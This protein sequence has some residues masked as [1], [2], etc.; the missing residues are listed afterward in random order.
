M[1]VH[2]L[3]DRQ[4]HI[5]FGIYVLSD[6]NLKDAVTYCCMQGLVDKH[7]CKE[8]LEQ[9]YLSE[10]VDEINS[11]LDEAHNWKDL[12]SDINKWLAEKTLYEWVQNINE[13]TAVAPSYELVY[14]QFNRIRTDYKLNCDGGSAYG[15]R[16]K[17]VHRWMARW[18]ATRAAMVSHEGNSSTE[19]V[20]KAPPKACNV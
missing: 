3:T 2:I 11:I 6:L 14:E 18:K 5:A 17:W 9:R 13:T 16:K 4:W 1:A 8:V 7:Y 15:C 19:I 10:S 12:R 20:Q